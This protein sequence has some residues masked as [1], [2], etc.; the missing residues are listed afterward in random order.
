MRRLITI[1]GMLVL[2]A[3]LKAD[4]WTWRQVPMQGNLGTGQNAFYLAHHPG[5]Q[6]VLLTADSG[7]G[8]V[9]SF[10][11][12]PPQWAPL[13]SDA[14]TVPAGGLG[15]FYFKT[16]GLVFDLNLGAPLVF[17][18]VQ[19]YAP[20]TSVMMMPY[21]FGPDGQ[22]TWAYPVWKKMDASDAGGFV[23]AYDSARRRT[24]IMGLRLQDDPS[25]WT[26]EFDGRDFTRTAQPEGWSFASGVAGFDPATRRTVFFGKVRD[27]HGP[28]TAEYDGSAWTLVDTEAAPRKDGWMTPLVFV[29]ALGGLVGVEHAVGGVVT[30]LY[31]DH[32]WTVLPVDRTFPPR[33][34]AQIAF[35]EAGGR[36]VLFGGTTADGGASN[37]VWELVRVPGHPRPVGRP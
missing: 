5:L 27:N 26:Q 33:P 7:S 19:E 29:P 23:T 14:M 28:E 31:K 2:A 1:A 21:V 9:A 10:A 34:R 32:A 25:R 3:A 4:S 22:W 17:G 12:D 11:L 13:G 6:K 18:I 35:D 8:S 30:W 15:Y 37:E 16:Q 36:L 20:G 24:V